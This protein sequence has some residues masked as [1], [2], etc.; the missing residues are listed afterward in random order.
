MVAPGLTLLALVHSRKWSR[1]RHDRKWKMLFGILF[2]AKL[3]SLCFVVI[4]L[5]MH[6]MQKLLTVHCST[7]ILIDLTDKFIN[8]IFI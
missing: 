7:I 2:W 4:D 1:F 8:H 5:H 6:Q 3:A